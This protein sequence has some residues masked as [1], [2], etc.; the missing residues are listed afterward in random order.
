VPI[1]RGARTRYHNVT[2]IIINRPDSG[3][4]FCEQGIKGTFDV[5]IT[6]YKTVR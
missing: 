1:G 6:G 4:V 2:H 5:Y 3:H